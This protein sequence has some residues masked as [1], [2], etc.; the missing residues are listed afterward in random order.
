M[1]DISLYS[2]D[3]DNA[4]WMIFEEITEELTNGKKECW[5]C[6]ESKQVIGYYSGFASL[7]D[8]NNL[9]T[10]PTC[11]GTGKSFSKK[12]QAFLKLMDKVQTYLWEP[13]DRQ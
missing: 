3:I 13:E 7:A 4:I 5:R 9:K 11:H 12:T 10:C 1:A 6:R 8:P 2:D